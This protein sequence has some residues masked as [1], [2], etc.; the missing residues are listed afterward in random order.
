MGSSPTFSTR[1][2]TVK[3]S[4][5]GLLVEI[6]VLGRFDSCTVH[7][8]LLKS[9]DLENRVDDSCRPNLIKDGGGT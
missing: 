1:S 8:I 5:V 9:D 6:L 7:Q 4:V 3:S 2:C